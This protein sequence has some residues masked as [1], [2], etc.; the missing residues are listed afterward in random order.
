MPEEPKCPKCNAP[1]ELVHTI[2]NAK[3]CCQCGYGPFDLVKDPISERAR[4][5]KA[6]ARGFGFALKV[7]DGRGEQ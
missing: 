2:A 3:Y 4:R 5:S 7:D 1:A 6:E